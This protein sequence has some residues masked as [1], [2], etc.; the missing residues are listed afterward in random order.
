MNKIRILVV[1]SVLMAVSCK[2][3]GKDL[4][5][6]FSFPERHNEV[7]GLVYDSEYKWF[8]A[9]EDKGNP[10]EL[11][12]FDTKGSPVKTL[13]VAGTENTDWEELAADNR[14]NLYIG[15]FGNNANKRKDLAIYKIDASEK[16]QAAA[17][18]VAQ[19]TTFY[20]PEQV[21]FP[22]SKKELLYD[23]EAFIATEDAFYLFTKNRSKGFDG[24][25]YIYKVPN[26]PG[27]FKAQRIQTLK[28]CGNYRECAITGAALSPDG[29]RV[30]VLTHTKLFLLS[31]PEKDA[32]FQDAVTTVE[33]HHNSQ[34]EAVTF[35][36][37]TT[38]FIADEKEKGS[39]EGGNV[40]RFILPETGAPTQN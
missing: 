17:V 8:F 14:N 31:F 1:F 32:F 15:N 6:L 38:L 22:P 33:L 7:S 40:Y 29:K 11:Y 18:G 13:A 5:V 36:D 21:K 27:H 19:T 24:S 25:F 16:E 9:L 28:T 4:N 37:E 30:A 20:Y 2:P 39:T 12:V 26:R 34:K 10:A 23:C 35:L 3:Q